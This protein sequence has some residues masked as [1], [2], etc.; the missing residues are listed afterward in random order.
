MVQLLIVYHYKAG[1]SRLMAEAA[2]STACEEVTTILKTAVEA[3]PEDLL[4]ADGYIFCAPEKLAA[5]AG[6]MKDFYYRSY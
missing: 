4:R 6:M 3:G 2:Y 5:I 1:G